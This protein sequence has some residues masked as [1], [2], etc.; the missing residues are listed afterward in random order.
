MQYGISTIYMKNGI[1]CA[2]APSAEKKNKPIKRS[3][4]D[5]GRTILTHVFR[6]GLQIC[7]FIVN[8]FRFDRCVVRLYSSIS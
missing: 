5:A 6:L 1:K 7:L 2:E 3:I 8:R 4:Y